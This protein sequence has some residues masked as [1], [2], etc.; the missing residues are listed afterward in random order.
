MPGWKG[1]EMKRYIYT[2]NLLIILF[3]L[4]A[5]GSSTGSTAKRTTT[6]KSVDDVLNEQMAKADNASSE[7]LSSEISEDNTV[8]SVVETTENDPGVASSDNSDLTSVSSETASVNDTLKEAGEQALDTSHDDI[9]VDLTLLSSTLIYSEVY[10][11]MCAPDEYIG[12]KIRIKGNT[13]IFHDDYDGNDYYACIIKDATACCSQGIEF[14][15]KEGEY[16]T[17]DEEITVTGV[18]SS[19]DINGQTFY[20]LKDAVLE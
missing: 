3:V 11:M 1:R 6:S 13:A 14:Q 7:D 20:T 5:C 17:E 8:E 2:L 18:Y 10:N 19:Y 16:P 12:K 15:L 4:T 9:Y